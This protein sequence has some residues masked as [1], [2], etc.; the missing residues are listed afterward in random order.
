MWAASRSTW[1][2]SWLYS[3]LPSAVIAA[4]GLR[5]SSAI[6]ESF[7]Q[8]PRGAARGRRSLL[9]PGSGAEAEVVEGR[10]RQPRP[11]FFQQ[12]TLL[13]MDQLLQQD[14]VVHEDIK[15]AP[16]EIAGASMLRSGGPDRLGPGA[17]QV[18]LSL[19]A[20]PA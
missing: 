4:V 17:L 5:T 8:S 15:H 13:E 9:L 11:Q 7:C 12:A 20:P 10:P 14:G 6:A 16:A 3:P 1:T 2:L 18:E 19:P